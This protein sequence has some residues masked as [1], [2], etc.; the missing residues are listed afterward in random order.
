MKLLNEDGQKKGECMKLIEK[1]TSE[2]KYWSA[3]KSERLKHG[4]CKR[5]LKQCFKVGRWAERMAGNKSSIQ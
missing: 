3:E 1:Q 5:K 2:R 4:H